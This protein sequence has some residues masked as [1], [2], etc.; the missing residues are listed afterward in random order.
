MRSIL[1]GHVDQELQQLPGSTGSL[2]GYGWQGPF[3]S[4]PTG[5]DTN[6]GKRNYDCFEC[7]AEYFAQGGEH[8]VSI[9]S[10]MKHVN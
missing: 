1:L 2:G 10:N 6:L 4:G 8:S 3:D 5:T 7:L 9:I